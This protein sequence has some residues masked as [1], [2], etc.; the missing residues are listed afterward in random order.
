L[1]I[2]NKGL[3]HRIDEKHKS[4]PKQELSTLQLLEIIS[5]LDSAMRQVAAVDFVL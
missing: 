4:D 1:Y 3:I 5:A 2:F